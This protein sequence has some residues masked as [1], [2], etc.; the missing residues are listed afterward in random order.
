MKIFLDT[1]VI[2]E[3][4]IEREDAATAAL[5]FSTIQEQKHDLYMS[6]G[7]VYTMIF[8]ID[9]YLKKEL[10]LASDTRVETLRRLVK[11]VLMTITVAGH[12]NE[13]MLKAVEDL[14]YKDLEDSC[15]HQAAAAACCDYLLTYNVKDYPQAMLP[16]L[17]PTEFLIQV[18]KR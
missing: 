5:L 8:L 9:R 3:Y 16:V 12:D 1:N 17:T 4:F 14:K 2:L 18:A 6:A 7:S 13:S 15:Q 11:D 10:G